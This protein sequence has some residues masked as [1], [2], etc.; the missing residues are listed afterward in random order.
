MKKTNLY[1]EQPEKV[2][3]LSDALAKYKESGCGDDKAFGEEH[4]ES[5]HNS[6]GRDCN[7]RVCG[8]R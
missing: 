2:E 8:R 4:D 7:G 3:M 5:I 1:T 6:I